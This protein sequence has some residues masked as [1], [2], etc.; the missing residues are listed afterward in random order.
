MKLTKKQAEFLENLNHWEVYYPD[1]T[2]DN[3]RFDFTCNDYTGTYD[4]LTEFTAESFKDLAEQ[5]ISFA[6]DYD[7]DQETIL[8]ASQIGLGNIGVPKK[9]RVLLEEYEEY[10]TKLEDLAL[11]FKEFLNPS[12]TKKINGL[13]RKS[14]EFLSQRPVQ[15]F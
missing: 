7:P 14:K 10:K 8:T 11:Q 2:E 1:E 3:M 5:V 4:T 12:S 13:D 15:Y 9:L 6:A